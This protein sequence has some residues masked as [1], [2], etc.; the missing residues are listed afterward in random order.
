MG[1][2]GRRLVREVPAARRHLAITTLAGLVAAACVVAQ[3]L[4]LAAVIAGAVGGDDLGDLV[5]PLVALA[6]VVVVRGLAA[7]TFTLSG[8]VASARAAAELRGRLVRGLLD[9]RPVTLHGAR[10]GDLAAAATTGI[11]ALE[12]FF[13]RYLPQMVLAAVVPVAILAVVV[14]VDVRSA[15]VMAVTVPL[16]PVFMIL[17]GK[18]AEARTRSRWRALSH[19]SAHFLDVVRGLETLRAHNRAD[20]Q[21]DA[22]R[23]VGDDHRRET[24]GTLRIAFLSALVL[25]LLAM[26]G[27]AL[28]AVTIGVR[29]AAGGMDLRTGLAVLILAPELYAPL[30]QLGVQ[31]HASADGT[32]AAE[33]IFRTLDLPPALPAGGDRAAPSPADGPIVL[34]GVS[35]TYP[36]SAAPALRDMDLQLAPGEFVAVTGPSGSGKS[37]LGLLLARLVA[38]TSGTLSAAGVDL[39]GVDADAWRRGVAWVPQRPRLLPATV[40]ANVRLARPE[41]GDEDVREALRSAGALDVV[42]ALP[43]GLATVVGEGGHGLSAGETRRVAIARAFLRDAPLV[44]LDE[45]TADLDPEAALH[46]A[47]AVL[48]LASGRTTLLVTH[49]AGL[50]ALADRIVEVVEGRV[51]M[52]VPA[53]VRE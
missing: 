5:A 37:T 7:G 47:E 3:A 31:F 36:G 45:P 52:P 11:E 32:A 10:Q 13:A 23:A 19:L 49:A 12:P 30:R 15:I 46:V 9:S 41:A 35:V 51:A 18:A 17:V 20:A 21:V 40:A 22:V 2:A 26:L 6:A 16:I 28:I 14:P 34:D 33:E 38:P 44:I 42:D 50:A 8:D 39:A 53:G 48:R 1:P 29:L 43:D 27:T 25:E 24:M 4:L